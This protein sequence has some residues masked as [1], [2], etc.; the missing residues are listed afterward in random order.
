MHKDDKQ[1]QW[2]KHTFNAMPRD[3]FTIR[4]LAEC[5]EDTTIQKTSML[6]QRLVYEGY[7]IR[8]PRLFGDKTPAY[9]YNPSAFN[10]QKTREEEI[11]D[12]I[13]QF[14]KAC[15]ALK[16]LY[17]DVE[18]LVRS[19]KDI[20]F[21]KQTAETELRSVYPPGVRQSAQKIFGRAA[22]CLCK[23]TT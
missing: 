21:D 15:K 18:I 5:Y 17:P 10:I 11:N 12:T 4:E 8:V 19:E 23:M 6:I 20:P 2:L 3:A 22:A 16:A 9:R 14:A 7:I 13:K 1:L